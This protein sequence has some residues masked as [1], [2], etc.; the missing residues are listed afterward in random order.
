MQPYEGLA[1]IELVKFDS[2]DPR[3]RARGVHA[4]PR[5]GLKP[6]D[7]ICLDHV[8]EIDTVLGAS[9]ARRRLLR[10]GRGRSRRGAGPRGRATRARG[11]LTRA[12]R[13]GRRPT[14]P[15]PPRRPR[16]L[17]P[18]RSVRAMRAESTSD[19]TSIA[20]R[21]RVRPPP[22]RILR[23]TSVNPVSPRETP[24]TRCCMT[25]HD[26]R[27]ADAAGADATPASLLPTTAPID[28]RG[29]IRRSA[30]AAL[31]GT[32]AATAVADAAQTPGRRRR[33]RDR[34]NGST[35][36]RSSRCAGPAASRRTGS[37]RKARWTTTS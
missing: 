17:D 35:R 2:A 37:G 20:S 19:V 16:P 9:G 8:A 21:D 14:P 11:Q 7:P 26:D 36:A 6:G 33:R 23:F 28:R 3:G 13:G 34:R 12:P 32:V 29:F 5:K 22:R 10:A 27:A 4:D 25:D 30:A 24:F 18:P 15:S 31:G 1:D